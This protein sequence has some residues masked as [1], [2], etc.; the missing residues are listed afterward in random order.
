M[1]KDVYSKKPIS[2]ASP[3]KELTKSAI[4]PIVRRSGKEAAG[5]AAE[6]PQDHIIY[7]IHPH[8]SA[9]HRWSQLMPVIMCTTYTQ[10]YPPKRSQEAGWGS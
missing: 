2:H 4:G 10:G 5:A 8:P 7:T 9:I 3:I 1:K 6:P